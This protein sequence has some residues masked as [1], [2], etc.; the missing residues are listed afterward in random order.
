MFRLILGV[1][2]KTQFGGIV[3][4]ILNGLCPLLIWRLRTKKQVDGSSSTTRIVIESKRVRKNVTMAHETSGSWTTLSLVAMP[5]LDLLTRP[6]SA[7]INQHS[8]NTYFELPKIKD[9][10]YKKNG[11]FYILLCYISL[12][13]IDDISK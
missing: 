3:S 6:L 13:Y 4:V 1:C 10:S 12:I 11:I 2:W 5:R 7:L 8:I 9:I